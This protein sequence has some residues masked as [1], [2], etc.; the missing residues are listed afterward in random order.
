MWRG[1]WEPGE[2]AGKVLVPSDAWAVAIP[3][4]LKFYNNLLLLFLLL[5][6]KILKF[7]VMNS[8]RLH[9]AASWQTQMWQKPVS[10]TI[11]ENLLY[12]WILNSSDAAT[13]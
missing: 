7:K 11:E 9:T 3:L 10:L 1:V 13:P 6:R 12:Q 5:S 8:P 2:Q 4:R